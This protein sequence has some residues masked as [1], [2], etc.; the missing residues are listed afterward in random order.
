MVDCKGKTKEGNGSEVR[1][2]TP[3]T[4]TSPEYKS[5]SDL[6]TFRSIS[7]YQKKNVVKATITG[8]IVRN[9]VSIGDLVSQGK[10]LYTVQTKEAKALDKFAGRDSLI[11]FKGESSIPAPSSGVVTEVNKQ[12]ND[13][14]SE[15]DQMCV[16]AEKNSFVF[17]L[18]V[19]YEQNRMITIG[20][21][22]RILLPDSTALNGTVVSKLST[23]DLAS[24][25]QVYVVKPNSTSLLSENLSAV[26]QVV[27]S[28]RLKAQVLNK[29]CVLAN[30]TM[31]AFWVMKLIN[32]SMAVKVPV[33]KGITNDSQVEILSPV[34]SPSDRIIET[35]NY[36]LA[37]TAYV[38]ITKP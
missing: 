7:S 15:G 27:K 20:K 8:Y 14:I 1:V 16:I 35:G 22:C 25:T 17:L 19:P 6:L 18:N 31:D 28:T 30:E 26:V 11:K 3:V 23:V 13:Y 29:S 24:Q 21:S 4:V 10:I 5:I 37:D 32:D 12:V 2:M 38:K 36:G 33:K 9:F 34:F